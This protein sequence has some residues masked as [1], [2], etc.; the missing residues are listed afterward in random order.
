MGARIGDRLRRGWEWFAALGLRHKLLLVGGFSAAVVL[1][2]GSWLLWPFWQL[3]GQF[4]DASLRQPSRLYGRP[5]ALAVGEGLDPRRLALELEELGYRRVETQGALAQGRYRQAPGRVLVSLRSFPTARGPAGGALLE[6]DLVGRRIVGLRLAGREVERALLEPP[7]LASYYGEEVEERRPVEV[8]ELPEHVVQAILAAEDERF[9]R[10]PGVSVQAVARAVLTNLRRREL[11]QGGS[12]LTQQL[13]KNL[14]LT[15]ERSLG[16][17]LRESVLAVLLEV[18][19]SKRQILEAYLNEIYMG[20]AGG[21]NL[22]GLGAA[23]RAYFGKDAAALDLAEAATLAGMIAAPAAYSPL[24]DPERSRQRRDWVLGRLAELEWIE[25]ERLERARRQPLVTAAQPPVR[26]RAPYFADAVALEAARRFRIGDLA[27][28]GYTLLSTLSWADQQAAE[29]AVD[30]GLPALEKGWQ[31]GA[32]AE[33]PLQAALVSLDP[34]DGSV[35]AYLGGRDYGAS[36]FDR[37]GQARRQ[38]GSAF[39][40]VVYAAALE[41]GAATPASLLEDAPLTVRL[42]GR[43]WE[44]QNDDEE[45]L[46]WVTVRSAVEQSRNVPTA[47]LALQTGLP[48]IVALAKAMGV[49]APLEPYPA[50]ALGAFE[51]TPVELATVYGTLAAEGVR[52][53]VHGLEAVLDPAGRALPGAPPPRPERALSREAAFLLTSVLQGVLDRGTAQGVRGAGLADP[54]AGKTGTTNGRRDSWFGGYAPERATVVWVGYDHNT[55]TRLSGARGALPIWTRFMRAVRPPGGYGS[56]RPPPGIVT[57]VI[58][59]ET[60]ELATDACPEILTEVFREDQV[61]GTICH[62]HGGWY[63]VPVDQPLDLGVPDRRSLR[64]W[65]DSVFGRRGRRGAGGPGGG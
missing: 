48:R 8:A 42:A 19:Y 65:L 10:H 53:P 54:L 37:A 40:P 6:V 64:R 61:P 39:K 14:Y 52:P 55:K 58:D 31:R 29:A 49:S 38:A 18:R 4:S 59:P 35:L 60:G 12:T 41:A 23:A 20:R 43:T 63:A 36:Q 2:A 25:P 22:H 27:D 34:R 32:R 51:L 26:R 57:A 28:G 30:W 45:F 1:V 46:G 9:F 15:H 16:R 17:K 50:L 13:V 11:Q 47:R 3:S 7:L 33:E 44:P 24:A 5:A 21:A 56:F 62:L